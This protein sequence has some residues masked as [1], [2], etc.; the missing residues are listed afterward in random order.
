MIL[1]NAQIVLADEVIKGTLH[2]NQ[3][4]IEAVDTGVVSLPGAVD[5]EG[6]YLMP[7][8]V[9]LHTDNMEKHFTPRPGVAWPGMQAFKV[10]DAQMI[11]AGITTVFD[12]ISVGDV[13]EGSE[14]LNNLNR[15]ANALKESGERGLTRA[16]HLLHLRCEVSHQDTLH[17]FRHLLESHPPQLV[18]IMDHAPGQRQF[19]NIDKYRQYYQGKYK[20]SDSEMEAFIVRQTEA[21]RLYSTDYRRAIADICLDLGIPLASHDDATL[22]H[23]AESLDHGMVI[24]EFPTTEVA[25][26]EAHRQGMA[27]LMGA[28]N[29]VRGGSHSGNVAAHALASEGLLDVLSSDYYPA[30]LLDA[31]FKLVADERNQYDLPSAT[32]LVSQRPAQAAG[33]ED[34]GEIA[35][36]KRADLVWC[37]GL[38]DHAH[39][40]H[41]W[42]D[43]NRV[44]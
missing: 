27:V 35:V 6:G 13:V 3:G 44:F 26:R 18:S 15:M 21:S 19:A 28:P 39:I 36:G 20:M 34:R 14:R 41:V 7:G 38:D 25:A 31:A 23:V 24:A 17:N 29:V 5:C 22:E 30:S 11:S 4:R 42:K 32:R 2:I 1:T 12:A 40:L 16:D 37:E 9:E 10:H 8:M 43:G 33:L